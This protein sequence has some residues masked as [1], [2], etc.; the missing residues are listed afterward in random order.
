[1]QQDY[2]NLAKR[3]PFAVLFFFFFFFFVSPALHV[4]STERQ[5][6]GV[7]VL[8]DDVSYDVR[9]AHFRINNKLKRKFIFCQ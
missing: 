1:M 5:R 2:S 9:S 6:H 7:H 8:F 4:L 3:F